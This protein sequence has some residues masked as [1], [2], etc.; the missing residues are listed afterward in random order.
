MPAAHGANVVVEIVNPAR[1]L[2][3][4]GAIAI[5]FGVLTLVWPTLTV[6]ALAIVFGVYALVD[7]VMRIVD[8]VRDHERPRRWVAVLSG[9]VSVAAGIVS[10]IWPG[11]T[12]LVLALLVGVWAVVTGVTD[13]VSAIRLRKQIR[14]EIFL[15]VIGILSV[16]A[17]ALI[18]FQPI[19]GALGIAVVIGAFAVLYGGVLVYLGYRLRKLVN[20]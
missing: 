7:G 6:L 4:R 3:V 16:V 17:G 15:V 11:I 10:L 12:A 8:A 9:V 13:I 1:T 2:L 20:V 5:A 19:A 18:I 14:G